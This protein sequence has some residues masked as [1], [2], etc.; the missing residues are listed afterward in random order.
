MN[1][2]PFKSVHTIII[3]QECGKEIFNYSATSAGYQFSLAKYARDPRYHP[4][5][6]GGY[7][8]EVLQLV[9]CLKHT[10]GR[11]TI[12]HYDRNIIL[13][14]RKPCP[15]CGQKE[16]SGCMKRTDLLDD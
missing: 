2:I 15:S 13:L 6:I 10:K 16:C 4:P 8:K 12:H 5:M 9:E 7:S 14:K 3:C 11:E 1:R